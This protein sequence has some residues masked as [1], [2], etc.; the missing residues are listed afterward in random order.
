MR[1]GKGKVCLMLP[2]LI[3]LLFASCTQSPE[4]AEQGKIDAVVAKMSLEE[5]VNLVVGTG[6]NLGGANGA[7][8]VYFDHA[9]GFADFFGVPPDVF[10]AAQIAAQRAVATVFFCAIGDEVEAHRQIARSGKQLAEFKDHGGTGGV[11]RCA[12]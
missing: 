12:G 2:V 1:V 9:P 3:G 5:K 10:D 8:A 7:D 11:V 4:E 6:M